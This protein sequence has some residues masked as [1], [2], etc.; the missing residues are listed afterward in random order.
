MKLVTGAAGYIGSHFVKAYL[1]CHPDEEVVVVDNLS[2]GHREALRFS[3]RIQFVQADVGD[4]ARMQAVLREYDVDAVI[5]F[6]ASCYVG[7]SQ[8][9]PEKYFRNNVVQTLGLLE[10][11]QAVRV[12]KLVFSS[13]CATYGNPLAS[14]V[15]LDSGRS[16]LASE[17]AQ[18]TKTT[19]AFQRIPI[20]ETHPQRPI[21]VY[22]TTKLM[23]EQALQIYALTQGWS[24]VALRYFN[25]CGA[26]ESGL[27]G[28]QHEPETHLI[29][30]AL[31][32]ALGQRS[33][34]H[35]YG[36]DYETPDGTC[37][38][39]YIH[40]NDLAQAHLLALDYL[41][42]HV[43]MHAFNLGTH[44]GSSVL[45]VVQTCRDV[46]GQTIPIEYA[47]RRL[48]DPPYLVADATQAEQVLG[49]KP[50]YTLRQ[51]V[52]TAWTWEQSRRFS[53]ATKS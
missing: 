15:S 25:A 26:D 24:Y 16:A 14:A 37:I 44:L 48:G 8:Q 17:F 4:V 36:N 49:W 51:M 11:M 43:G 45:E 53:P 32:V 34:L 42:S 13:T 5:H 33:A 2:E 23:I 10:A 1:D 12:K 39:D 7:E 52:E 31:Q 30:L 46:T 28:E 29:P 20:D 18:D 6:A 47:A 41:G 40:V 38:R 22:G 9:N 21:N 27:L 3:S 50:R 35:I 19:R